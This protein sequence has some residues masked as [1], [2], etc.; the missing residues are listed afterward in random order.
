MIK[1]TNPEDC[2]GCS[3]CEKVCPK[4]CITMKEDFEG[5]LYPL[6]D[7]DNC[8]DCGLCEKICPVI[9][10]QTPQ[11]P[12]K[13]YAARNNDEQIRMK[14][15]SGG[16]F[17][18]LAEITISKGGVVFGACFDENW[19]VKHDYV[20]T[21]ED[22]KRLRGSKYV[23]SNMGDCYS[24]AKD[25]LK[26]GREVLFSGTPCQIAGLKKFLKHDY[27]S[28]LTVDIIC[29]GVPSRKVWRM[30]I[31]ELEKQNYLF[32]NRR[33]TP[34]RIRDISFRNK[35]T[36]WKNYNFY[37]SIDF[38]DPISE[39]FYESHH[40]NTFMKAFLNNLCLRPSCHNCPA[41]S[42]K[43]KSDITIADY[44]SIQ[45]S[46][47]EVDDDKGT[48]SVLVNTLK[49]EQHYSK[50]NATSIE[51]ELEIAQRYNAGY[52]TNIPKHINREHFFKLLDKKPNIS[53]WIDE[54]LPTEPKCKTLNIINKLFRKS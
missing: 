12:I 13:V 30:Y 26:Q 28:L 35:R 31:N 44:W 14:S 43:S 32:F 18:S 51:T 24:Q 41:K 7:L 47:P 16:I 11:Q 17:T 37:F 5:F 45:E 40:N 36:G 42:G 22:L 49:G 1:L 33:L 53:H 27:D 20:E 29:H 46:L 8:I 6:I 48:N 2:C 10:P 9:N 50:T 34:K 4:Q 3:A 15:S 38:R 19:E 39:D 25:F 23:Q 52:L 21:I 54:M